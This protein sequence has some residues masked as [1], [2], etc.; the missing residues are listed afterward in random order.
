M[1]SCLPKRC[2]RLAAAGFNR[3][4]DFQSGF[5]VRVVVDDH[6]GAVGAQAF[7]DG[8]ANAARTPGDDRNLPS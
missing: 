8:A 2:D 1:I 6:G 3:S 4:D 5:G 7:G